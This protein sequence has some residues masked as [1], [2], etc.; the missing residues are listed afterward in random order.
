MFII[1][2]YYELPELAN[3]HGLQLWLGPVESVDMLRLKLSSSNSESELD[4]SFLATLP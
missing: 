4:L 2:H 1:A 3:L